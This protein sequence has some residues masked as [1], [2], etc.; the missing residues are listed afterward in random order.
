MP[1]HT[2][3]PAASRLKQ[4]LVVKP[5]GF[6]FDLHDGESFTLNESARCLVHALQKGAVPGDL[7][8][9]LVADFEVSEKQARRDVAR[10]LTEMRSLGL[11]ARE[12][13]R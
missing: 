3:I 6:I 1:N 10:F 12:A 4:S 5:T 9:N 2:N 7:W 11:L 8:K 13:G